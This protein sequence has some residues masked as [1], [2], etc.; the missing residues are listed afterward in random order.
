[1]SPVP[2]GKLFGDQI[3]SRDASYILFVCCCCFFPAYMF[4]LNSLECLLYLLVKLFGDQ[5][6]PRDASHLLSICCCCFFPAYMFFL[7]MEL[8][9]DFFSPFSFFSTFVSFAAFFD[10]KKWTLN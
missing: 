8:D 5:N 6:K 3:K 4:Y 7:L 9:F 10:L 1:M 2:V